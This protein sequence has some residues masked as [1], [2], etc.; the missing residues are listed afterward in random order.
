MKQLGDWLLR[1]RKELDMSQRAVEKAAGVSNA[2]L[3]QLET[4]KVKTPSPQILHKLSL[5]YDFPYAKLMDLAGYPMPTDGSGSNAIESDLAA[6][7]GPVT[8]S[9]IDA[10][11]EYLAFLRSKD[12]RK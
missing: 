7:I 8:T 4:G 1:R 6:R 10:L 12:A 3:S 2:Y 9:E 5:L 11:T